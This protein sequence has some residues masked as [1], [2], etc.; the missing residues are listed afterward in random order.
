MSAFGNKY[1]PPAK[2]AGFASQG[3]GE[4]RRRVFVWLMAKAASWEVRCGCAFDFVGVALR[5]VLC[6]LCCAVL[7][8]AVLCCAVLCCAVL[9]CAVSCAVLWCAPSYAC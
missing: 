2:E 7:C 3:F 6:A 8:C 9:C 1:L 5:A 4:K